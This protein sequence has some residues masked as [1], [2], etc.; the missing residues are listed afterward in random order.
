MMSNDICPICKGEANMTRLGVDYFYECHSCGRLYVQASAK[1]D[2]SYPASLDILSTY[3]YYNNRFSNPL[4][5][6]HKN[7][8]NIIG[9]ETF[10]R[11][12][13]A[14]YP[15]SLEVTKDVVET[16]YPQ[17]FDEQV[18]CFLSAL[19]KRQKY[20]G[21]GVTFTKAML[22]SACFVKCEDYKSRLESEE[23]KQQVDFFLSYLI[24]EKLIKVS[25]EEDE[26]TDIT[27]LHRG[28]NRVDIL[29]KSKKSKHIFVA[30]SFNN[31]T[32]STREAIRN[33]IAAAGFI[34][35]YID[36][37]IHNHQIMPEMF[38]LIRESHILILDI[39]Y[40]NYGSY[41]E[42]G[43]ALGLGK[44]VIVCCSSKM[45]NKKYE[46]E[47]E[48]KFERYLRPHFDILQKQILIWDDE[49]DLTKKLSEWIKA[50]E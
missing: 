1:H 42:A 2:N 28:L 46:A 15:H 24:D 43:Y 21:Q 44:E 37:I 27:L 9:D 25:R 31:D 32:T 40:P 5:I 3:L 45:F 23:S 50:I 38:R 20:N 7:F 26:I 48:K 18:D 36:E 12:I 39:S 8:F 17:K 47:E 14:Y 10:E 19:Y 33:G 35:D 13:R 41:Y 30:M 6:T 49:S 11:M 22:Y 34:P 29:G 16:W 4:G